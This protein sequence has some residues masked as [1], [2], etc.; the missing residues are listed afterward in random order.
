MLTAATPDDL[1]IASLNLEQNGLGDPGRRWAAYER[2]REL[3]VHLLFR[4]EMNGADLDRHALMYEAEDAL[5]MRCW[6][7]E[8]S[9]TAVFADERI[10]KPLGHWPTPW[11]RFKLPPAAVTLQ[12]RAAGPESTPPIAVAAHLNYAVPALRDIEAGWITGF[13]D[14][15]VT[16]PKD[17]GRQHAVMLAGLDGNSYPHQRTAAEPPLPE[18]DKI[19]DR[20]HRAHR[21]RTGP[22]G[23]RV[24]DQDP[25]EILHEAGVRDI[26]AYLAQVP[27][28]ADRL[29]PTMLASETHGPD[30]R[31]DWLMASHQLLPVFTQ[32]AVIDARDISDHNL[33]IANASASGLA[34]L[35][36]DLDF[37]AA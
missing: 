19:Q 11:T 26:A 27:G 17:G 4:Q 21:S 2:I 30:A 10:F 37:A 16:L 12:L 15:W 18:R 33:V 36:S 35:L 5:G 22:D 25:H 20:P 13:N 14:K 29:D 34:Q 6:L 1:V 23:G 24:V 3:G 28:G 9:A 32:V 31:V 7:S 8:R